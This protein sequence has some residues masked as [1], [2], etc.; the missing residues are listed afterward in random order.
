MFDE[1]P[2]SHSML[3][4]LNGDAVSYGLAH[5]GVPGRFS[6]WGDVLYDGPIPRDV[7]DD[8]VA[9]ARARFHAGEFISYEDALA[10]H[11]RWDAGLASSSDA[12]EVVLWFEHD[13]HD[14]MLLIRQLDWFARRPVRRFALSLICIGEFASVE[15]FHGLG[16]LT[17]VQ[18]ASLL[19]TR[20]RVT[21]RQLALGQ[22]MWRAF[23][24]EDPTAMEKILSRDTSVLPFLDGA[25]R[26]LLEEFPESRTGLPRTERTMLELLSV[27]GPQ[28]FATLFPLQQKTEERVFMGDW[29]FW[30]RV[31]DLAR[32]PRPLVHIERANGEHFLHARLTI[33]EDGRRALAAELDWMAIAP[34]D[35]WIGGSHLVAPNVGCRWHASTRRLQISA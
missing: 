18:L 28:S 12:D 19:D 10:M 21:E 34:V 1:P 9:D 22:S 33:T 32:G 31:E 14:Q 30:S 7:D 26:R 5:S 27:H 16:Q 25:M 23:T 35:R 11:R 24:G 17:P 6:V 3:H 4:I 20:Q 15:P 29:T 8:T 2:V 13:L